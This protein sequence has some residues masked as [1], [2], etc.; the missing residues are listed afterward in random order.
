MA[1]GSRTTRTHRFWAQLQ[2]LAILC[3]GIGLEAGAARA[4]VV[5]MNGERFAVTI[6]A[7]TFGG[8]A[9]GS[10]P[11]WGSAQSARDFS[12]AVGN[13]LVPS[14]PYPD[15]FGNPVSYSAPLFG[16]GWL[17]LGNIFGGSVRIKAEQFGHAHSDEILVLVVRNNPGG[18]PW[19]GAAIVP[20]AIATQLPPEPPP[21][22]PTAPGPLPLVGVA[23]AF[24]HSRRLRRGYRSLVVEPRPGGV[25]GTGQG[26]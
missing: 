8:V 15:V 22:P 25:A 9:L 7:T 13:Q 16:W 2:A 1:G 21:P 3:G 23:C 24:R 14:G 6:A 17:S 11:W 18:M 19:S 26:H 5:T 10:Q 4:V 20:W 12:N